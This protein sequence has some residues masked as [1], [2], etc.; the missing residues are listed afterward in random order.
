MLVPGVTL[1]VSDALLSDAVWALHRVTAALGADSLAGSFSR[2]SVL[3]RHLDTLPPGPDRTHMLIVSITWTAV[4]F[5]G[6]IVPMER[7]TV[8]HRCSL[9][10][11]VVPVLSSCAKAK[12]RSPINRAGA[13]RELDRRCRA[14]ERQVLKAHRRVGGISRRSP[15]QKPALRH[16]H[17]VAGALR[18]QLA[19]LD[20]TPDAGIEQLAL[21]VVEISERH[22]TGR[23]SQLL[24][25]EVL[26]GVVPV[27]RSST[28]IRESVHVAAVIAAALAAVITVNALVPDSAVSSDLRP[29]LLAGAAAVTAILIGGWQRVVRL[30]EALPVK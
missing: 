30:L 7:R 14:F 19:R 15:R 17:L 23:V 12:S 22:A 28:A 10:F 25:Q 8:L 2:Y 27:S 16:A 5:V 13:L 26:N 1:I 24:P 21:M 11:Q 9:T 29:W 3:M 18:A 6:A 4:L 20:M